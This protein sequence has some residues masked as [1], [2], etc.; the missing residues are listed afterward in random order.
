M[1]RILLTH[2]II[3][4]S[5]TVAFAQGGWRILENAPTVNSRF[6]DVYFLNPKTGWAVSLQG[7]VYRTGDGGES[8]QQ[9]YSVGGG[10]FRSVGFADSLHGWI[11]S[12]SGPDF[13]LQTDDGG[14]TWTPATIQGRPIQGICGISVVNDSVAFGVGRFD[15]TP[16]LAKTINA[17]ATW[18]VIDMSGY[19]QTL[20]DCH[21]FTPDTGFATGGSPTGE[22]PRTIKTVVLST[23]DGGVTWQ[24]RKLTTDRA[25]ATGGEWGWKLSFPS[26][27]VGYAAIERLDFREGSGYVLRTIDGGLT[28]DDVPIGQNFRIQGVGML[29]EDLGWVGGGEATYETSDGGQTWQPA[30]L[31]MPNVNRFRF[32]G[33]TLGY[34]VGK[35][36]YKYEAAGMTTHVRQ[37]A[38]TRP[39]EFVLQQNYPNPFNPATVI[40]YDLSRESEV[41]LQVFNL[42][43]QKVATLVH[44]RQ[45]RG[46]HQVV[47]NGANQPSGVYYYTLQN[48]GRMQTRKM[49]LLR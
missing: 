22:F 40:S 34:A 35:Q 41:R 32:F 29:T 38:Q 45:P 7:R 33:D 6:D 49:L 17:G 24:T 11:G 5:A 18:D 15:G 4:L 12:L 48:G 9:I 47:F 25:D 16:R 8:W 20:V 39:Q 14:F 28:W 10:A 19:A 21:F 27:R 13:L 36:I 30:K 44:G 37:V 31:D 2:L 23:D 43:G 26:R 3:S 46:S 1:N 42:T